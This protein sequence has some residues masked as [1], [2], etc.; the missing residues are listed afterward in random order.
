MCASTE[1]V[2]RIIYLQESWWREE[3]M[4]LEEI[5]NEDALQLEV[6]LMR[7]EDWNAE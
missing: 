7:E 1:W 5:G 3:C 2:L 6:P 4:D